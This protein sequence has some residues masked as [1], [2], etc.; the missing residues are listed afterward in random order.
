MYSLLSTVNGEREVLPEGNAFY[1]S[2]CLSQD[3]I[4]QITLSKIASVWV[5][6]DLPKA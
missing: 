3:G 5:L 1:P 4:S 6:Q 2:S